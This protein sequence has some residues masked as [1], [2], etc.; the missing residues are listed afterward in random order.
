MSTAENTF[1][2]LE[3][4][5]VENSEAELERKTM[6]KVEMNVKTHGTKWSSLT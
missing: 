5:T 3:D 2:E 4:R 6:E 1:S